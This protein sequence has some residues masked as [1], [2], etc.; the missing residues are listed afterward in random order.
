MK[1]QVQDHE[2]ATFRDF[3]TFRDSP[4]IRDFLRNAVPS[5]L[6]RK[7]FCGQRKVSVSIREAAVFRERA[8]IRDYRR[9]RLKPLFPGEICADRV[10]D[11]WCIAKSSASMTS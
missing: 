6:E 8:S 3:A 7:V 2:G 4:I 10:R 9:V 11:A 5:D 1:D